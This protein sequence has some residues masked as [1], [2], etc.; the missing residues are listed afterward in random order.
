MMVVSIFG[1]VLSFKKPMSNDLLFVV[2]FWH[3]SPNF[4]DRLLESLWSFRNICRKWKPLQNRARR[5]YD[6]ELVDQSP[7]KQTAR[8]WNQNKIQ[9]RTKVVRLAETLSPVSALQIQLDR[10]RVVS[11]PKNGHLV[12]SKRRHAGFFCGLFT[13]SLCITGTSL[14]AD[15]TATSARGKLVT[16]NDAKLIVARQDSTSRTDTTIALQNL[17]IE[18]FNHYSILKQR[19]PHSNIPWCNNANTQC[20]KRS[21]SQIGTHTDVQNLLLDQTSGESA[22]T[23]FGT[24]GESTHCHDFRDPERPAPTARYWT[25]CKILKRYIPKRHTNNSNT[26]TVKHV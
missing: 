21:N 18:R 24:F 15:L 22:G 10:C 16:P 25:W 26:H 20:V 9:A 17:Q 5:I 8:N 23:V 19:F 1:P 14:F 2:S 13:G 4:S 7:D 3:H 6:I 12:R 11:R